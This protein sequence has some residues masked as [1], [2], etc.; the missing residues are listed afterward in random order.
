MRDQWRN[1]PLVDTPQAKEAWRA[2]GV[3]DARALA[4]VSLLRETF[5]QSDPEA[6][7]A[8][9]Q[10]IAG[11]LFSVGLDLHFALG[12]TTHPAARARLEGTIHELDDVIKDVRRLALRLTEPHDAN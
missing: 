4:F 7:V 5:A 11:R 3:P 1:Q 6:T 8:L 9:G 12:L 2:G 10:A